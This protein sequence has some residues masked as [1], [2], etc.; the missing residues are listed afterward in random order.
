[1]RDTG[2]A[3][4][5]SVPASRKRMSAHD[6][7]DSTLVKLLVPVIVTIAVPLLSWGGGKIL[8]RMDKIESAISANTTLTATYE[9][10][11]RSRETE[12]DRMSADLRVMQTL[13]S[14]MRLKVELL[15]QRSR[16]ER[17]K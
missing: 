12:S 7:A 8:D 16:E 6:I 2:N 1:M 3:E 15:E 13:L 14:D 17:R 5:D 10:R 11:L 9:L 4:L